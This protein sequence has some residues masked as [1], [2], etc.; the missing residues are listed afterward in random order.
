MGNSEARGPLKMWENPAG[1]KDLL[2]LGE[3]FDP[4]TVKFLPGRTT[5]DQRRGIALPFCDRIDVMRRLDETVGPGNWTTSVAVESVPCRDDKGVERPG[6]YAITQLSVRCVQ[7]WIGKCDSSDVEPDVKSATTGAFK[8]AATLWG[9]GRYLAE[10]PEVWVDLEDKRIAAAELPKLRRLLPVP[11]RPE[12]APLEAAAPA[13]EEGRLRTA[14]PTRGILFERLKAVA[15]SLELPD[16][17]VSQVIKGF[18]FASSRQMSVAAL[19]ALVRGFE[20]IATHAAVD[21]KN[22]EHRAEINRRL[23][24]PRNANDPFAELIAHL[25]T[26]E[27]I[28]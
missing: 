7:G 21:L 11:S 4:E 27:P 20:Q 15:K 6:F 16:R 14:E 5:K 24:S 8:R 13:P 17:T 12:P 9:I 22:P 23:V 18:G 25:D 3:P 28:L 10:F 26:R 19:A 2:E 1:P